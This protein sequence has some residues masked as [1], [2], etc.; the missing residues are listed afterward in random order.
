MNN[1][2]LFMLLDSIDDKYIAD[3]EIKPKATA[4]S[5]REHGFWGFFNNAATIVATVVILCAI[6]VWTLVGKDILNGLKGDTSTDENPQ[7]TTTPHE[8]V[9]LERPSGGGFSEMTPT[10]ITITV[11]ERVTSLQLNLVDVVGFENESTRDATE[12]PADKCYYTVACELA[13][14]SGEELHIKKIYDSFDIEKISQI[15]SDVKF[16]STDEDINNGNIRLRA[17]TIKRFEDTNVTESYALDM[18]EGYL[19]RETAAGGFEKSVEPLSK[20]DKCSFVLAYFMSPNY[21][22]DSIF[23]GTS[24]AEGYAY[25]F[26]FNGATRDSSFEVTLEYAGYTLTLD[27]EASNSFY[28]E[29]LGG[30]DCK[31]RYAVRYGKREL[32]AENCIKYTCKITTD[33]GVTE[34]VLYIDANNTVILDTPK[35]G[36]SMRAYEITIMASASD[37][38]YMTY[39]ALS[40]EFEDIL[41]FMQQKLNEQN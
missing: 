12:I 1:V 32:I 39:D 14:G 41:S 28:D 23:N 27:N 24:A 29:I 21:E 22:I 3:A 10:D 7:E 40:F 35:E 36:E 15:L 25:L 13:N 11:Y 34:K 5:D 38:I 8:T 30:D 19:Y 2:K 9:T 4:I 18:Y 37:D 17:I 6:I 16:E 26:G 33:A 20:E 31:L